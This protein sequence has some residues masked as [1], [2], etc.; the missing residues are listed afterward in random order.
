ME[1]QIFETILK[2]TYTVFQFKHRLRIL[3]SNFNQKFY[4]GDLQIEPAEDDINWMKTLP[5]TFFQSFTADNQA[6]IFTFLEGK[7]KETPALTLNLAFNPPDELINEMGEF[8]RQKFTSFKLIDLKFDLSLI[9]GCS[10][11]WKGAY[12]DYSLKAR[13]EERKEEIMQ[14]F[15]KF[16]R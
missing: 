4:G 1:D 11:I 10:M 7:L 13:I 2:N 16:L 9:A 3:K 5:Q 8:Y 6:Q 15:R 14:S 12:K